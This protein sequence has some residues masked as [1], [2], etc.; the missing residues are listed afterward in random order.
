[1]AKT[2]IRPEQAK[3]LE[4]FDD[5]KAA[6]STLEDPTLTLEGFLQGVISQ[7]NR[8]LHTTAGGNDWFAD[9][10]APVSVQFREWFIQQQSCRLRQQDPH[11]GHPR[12]LPA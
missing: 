11:Q 3:T 4:V 12:L 1:M 8:V 9:L 6:G 5:Q 2:R 7:V 10:V